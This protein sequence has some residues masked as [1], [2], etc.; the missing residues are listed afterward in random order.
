MPKPYSGT[1]DW[2]CRAVAS[3]Q[4]LPSCGGRALPCTAFNRTQQDR[5]RQRRMPEIE[6]Y[7]RGCGGDVI[8]PHIR[9]ARGVA[10]RHR[11]GSQTINPHQKLLK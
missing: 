6:P 7:V 10:P 4:G 2:R 11:P 9:G 3:A 5:L 1:I 8:I